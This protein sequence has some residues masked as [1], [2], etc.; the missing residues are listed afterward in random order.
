MTFPGGKAGAGVYQA[1]INQMPPH[2]TYY[3]PFAGGGAILLHK[4]P[5]F[6]TIICDL[7]G[8]SLTAIS[9]EA[10]RRNIKHHRI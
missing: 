7:D 6:D 1:I 10:R 9:D 3:E 5:A 4:R 8:D 2:K